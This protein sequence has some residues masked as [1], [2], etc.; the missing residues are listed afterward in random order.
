MDQS[1]L[2][3][4]EVLPQLPKVNRSVFHTQQKAAGIL[5]PVSAGRRSQDL[6]IGDTRFVT[7]MIDFCAAVGARI[8]QFLSI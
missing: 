4:I 8:Y 6:G 2:R 3:G 1:D 5:L 7:E